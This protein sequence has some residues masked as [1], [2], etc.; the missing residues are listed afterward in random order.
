VE[1]AHGFDNIE[2]SFNGDEVSVIV[3]M[4]SDAGEES[5]DNGNSSNHDGSNGGSLD[6]NDAPVAS[7]L[8]PATP[9][10]IEDKT[11]AVNFLQ[12][13]GNDSP[14]S[15]TWKVDTTLPTPSDL[16]PLDPDDGERPNLCLNAYNA[17]VSALVELI[18]ETD[19]KARIVAS[20]SNGSCSVMLVSSVEQ[21]PAAY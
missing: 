7:P 6:D 20:S 8:T 1:D 11:E 5:V 18:G 12:V 15:G 10:S 14:L 16:P 13:V 2:G 17:S 9:I 19:E 21:F 3:S 4:I